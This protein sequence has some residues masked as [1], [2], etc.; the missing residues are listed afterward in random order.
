MVRKI[1]IGLGVLVV[2]AAAAIGV[3][4]ATLHRPDLPY[5]ELDKT[6]GYPEAETRLVDLG[7]GLI[8]HARVTGNRDGRTLIL[9]HGY[10]ASAHTWEPLIERL[11]AD[12]RLI[13]IDLPGHG[14]TRTPPGY[15]A[16]IADFA[17]FVET[18]AERLGLPKAVVV[19]SSMG[20]HTAWQL[21][22]QTPGRVDGLVLIGAAGWPQ[23]D[24][25][26]PTE[27]PVTKMM[28]NPTV[29][30]ILR[31]LDSTAIFTQGLR[32]SFANPDL[33]TPAMIKRYVDLSRAPGHRPVILDLRL[34]YDMRTLATPELMAKIAQPT[35]ILHGDKDALVPVASGRR[36]D[37]TIPNSKYV[38]YPGVGHMP[39]EEITDQVAAEISAFLKTVY[40]EPAAGAPLLT[41]PGR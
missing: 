37:E 27:T 30:P 19:G 36:F 23:G 3:G 24:G 9:V 41:P 21:A 29:G 33:A 22:L 31:D 6:Y 34:N 5:A 32:A 17:S 26:N 38:E 16:T 10:T 8:A 2:L 13:A 39:H 25:A 7:D 28:R 18:V 4:F 15:K 40:P 12:H 1:I 14:L 20:G 11:K 35:L